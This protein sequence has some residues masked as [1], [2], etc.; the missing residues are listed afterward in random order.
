MPAPRVFPDRELSIFLK[1]NQSSFSSAFAELVVEGPA[2]LFGF[3]P[4][5]GFWAPRS[6]DRDV[7]L[8]FNP[9]GVAHSL[10]EVLSYFSVIVGFVRFF[11]G[12]CGLI[13]ET[14]LYMS[15]IY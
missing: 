1:E 4:V 12:S 10:V 8:D 7:I 15:D 9:I 6:V 14:R 3:I 2:P 11:R 5:F 13:V